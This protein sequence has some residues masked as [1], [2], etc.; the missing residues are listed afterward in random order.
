[1]PVAALTQRDGAT[2]VFLLDAARTS[3]SW[4]PVEVGAREGERALIA[5]EPFEGEVVVLGQDGCD[6]GSRVVPVAAAT[7]DVP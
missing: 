2:G 7:E 6:D 1:V 3:V 5:G 4:R